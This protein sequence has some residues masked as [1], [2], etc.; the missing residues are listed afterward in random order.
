MQLHELEDF[1]DALK[2]KDPFR[3]ESKQDFYSVAWDTVSSFVNGCM[4]DLEN[5]LRAMYTDLSDK[6]LI[7]L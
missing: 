5:F 7:V 6:A 3:L 1:K 4:N 2:L